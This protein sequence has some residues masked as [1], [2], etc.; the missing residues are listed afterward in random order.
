M[1]ETLYEKLCAL[2][3]SD[4]YPFHMPGHKRMETG[5]EYDTSFALDITEIPGFDNL[6]HPEGILKEEMER[7]ASF[8]QT[9]ATF[10]LVNGSSCGVLSSIF[11]ATNRKDE[12]ILG[13]NSH[14]SAYHAL[15]LNQLKATYLYPDSVDSNLPL[16]PI[17][18]EDVQRALEQSKAK[19]VFLTSPSYEGVFCEIKKIAEIVHEKGGILIVDE[20]HGAHLPFIKEFPKSAISSGADLVIQSLHKTMPTFTQTALLHVCSERVDVDKVKQF[21]SIFQTSSPSYVFMGSISKCLFGDEGLRRQRVE[22]YLENLNSFY[23]ECKTLKNISVLDADWVKKTYGA[24]MDPSKIVICTKNARDKDGNAYGGV[25]LE[26]ELRNRFHLQVEMVSS[27]Y[28]IAMTS[29]MDTKEGFDRLKQGLAMLDQ[30]LYPVENGSHQERNQNHQNEMTEKNLQQYP[31][32]V[33][34]I[35]DALCAK[36]HPVSW[37]QSRGEI[38]GEYLY[39]YPPGSPILAPGERISD[40]VINKVQRAKEQ[41]LNLQGIKDDSLQKIQ[42]LQ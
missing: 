14:K 36:T 37:E 4:E 22:R 40:T 35:Y 10:Y 31:E 18:P 20:A 19:V 29:M 15:Y 17:S 16:G 8:Y 25:F 23:Q 33:F 34:S 3:N 26:N 24:Q 7:A 27:K 12:I 13:R 11:A 30:E 2:K 21:L 5:S 6:H 38:S 42:V 39:L 1:N 41:G 32:V 28:V 9:K